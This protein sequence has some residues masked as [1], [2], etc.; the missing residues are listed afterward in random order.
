M[1][2]SKEFCDELLHHFLAQFMRYDWLYGVHYE[3]TPTL[4]N[5]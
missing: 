3:M 4:D 2:M 5:A 1:E